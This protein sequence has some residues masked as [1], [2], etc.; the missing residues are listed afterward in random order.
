VDQLVDS[1][2]GD[3][4]LHIDLSQEFLLRY[5]E[6]FIA[7]DALSPPFKPPLATRANATANC[8]ERGYAD[9]RP[10]AEA[11]VFSVFNALFEVFFAVRLGPVTLVSI[12]LGWQ[13]TVQELEHRLVFDKVLVPDDQEGNDGAHCHDERTEI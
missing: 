13:L 1:I 6:L 2:H 9:E 12:I 5:L 7:V 3:K 10:V 11:E 4:V 8:L